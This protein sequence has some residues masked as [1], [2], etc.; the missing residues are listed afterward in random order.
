MDRGQFGVSGCFSLH[1]MIQGQNPGCQACATRSFP[2]EPFA[3][4]T[5]SFWEIT[6]SLL[7]LETPLC[8][9]KQIVQSICFLMLLVPSSFSLLV[10][11][12][13]SSGKSP[14]T[15]PVST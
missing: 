15:S 4:P 7:Y 1:S 3:G 12:S 11:D 6:I 14:I 10:L 13:T 9:R 2:P 8:L 5:T